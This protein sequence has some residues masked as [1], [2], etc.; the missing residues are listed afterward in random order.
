MS[1][2]VVKNDIGKYCL[3]EKE[4]KTVISLGRRNET[5]ARSICRKLN[6]GSGFCGWTPDFFAKK[7]FTNGSV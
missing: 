3:V 1:Y 7:L 5:E 2:S 6:L 4:S